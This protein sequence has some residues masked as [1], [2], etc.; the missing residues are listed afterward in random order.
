MKLCYR[1][2]KILENNNNDMDLSKW[3]SKADI[4]PL[5]KSLKNKDDGKFPSNQEAIE[6]IVLLWRN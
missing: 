1:T 3:K 5:L 6:S 4:L 2:D